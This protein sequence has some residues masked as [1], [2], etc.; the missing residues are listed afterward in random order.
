M[1][2]PSRSYPVGR[3]DKFG[4]MSIISEVVVCLILE[5]LWLPNDPRSKRIRRYSGD[6][7]NL[8]I[9]NDRFLIM[10]VQ[11]ITLI[12]KIFSLKELF[13]SRLNGES[14]LSLILAGDLS[15]QYIEIA[16]LDRIWC[17]AS[18]LSWKECRLCRMPWD[19]N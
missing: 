17:P 3:F 14:C 19:K 10:E 13:F 16:L 2:S 4:V 5:R 12:L 1:V 15:Y 11:M 8:V 9:K 6:Q 18:A 7:I